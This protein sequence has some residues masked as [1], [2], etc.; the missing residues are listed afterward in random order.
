MWIRSKICGITRPEDAAA[1][2]A[3]GADAIGLVFYPASPRAVEITQAQQ[4]VAV[5]PP[6]VSAVGLFV[7]AC[8]EDIHAVLRQVPLDILQFHGDEDDAFCRQF[9]RPYLKAVRVRQA[10]DIQAACRRFPQARALLFDAYHPQAYGGTGQ[11]FDWTWL[12]EKLS[13][14][15]IL[16]GGLTPENVAAAVRISGAVAVDVSGGVESAPGIKDAGKMAA[17]VTAVRAART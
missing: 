3:V 15:W 1:A 13:C 4:I 12:P 5:L 17:F 14:P 6:L 16:A 11:C 8:A 10:A 7:N 9:E 2:A